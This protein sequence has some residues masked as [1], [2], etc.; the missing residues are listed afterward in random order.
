MTSNSSLSSCQCL[1]SLRAALSFHL[2][3]SPFWVCCL[4]G[5][6]SLAPPPPIIIIILVQGSAPSSSS[7]T[8]GI[9]E[10]STI[11]Q[12]IW[13]TVKPFY[14]PVAKFSASPPSSLLELNCTSP[15]A[16][17][18]HGKG[19][20]QALTRHRLATSC[21]M[22]QHLVSKCRGGSRPRKRS[23]PGGCLR[24]GPGAQTPSTSPTVASARMKCTPQA[25]A[26]LVAGSS[27]EPRL[28]IADSLKSPSS[29]FSLHNLQSHAA[30]YCFVS[31]FAKCL[32]AW[33]SYHIHCPA[34]VGSLDSPT[35][36]PTLPP[37]SFPP[38][39]PWESHL[40]DPLFI[41]ASASVT[42]FPSLPSLTFPLRCLYSLLLP[43]I[44]LAF[45]L[46]PPSDRSASTFL[47][48]RLFSPLVDFSCSFERTAYD[49]LCL[50][51][52]QN[53][54]LPLK[55]KLTFCENPII[56]LI[57]N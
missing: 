2:I 35:R 47:L 45:L 55:P 10:S 42:T 44:S 41:S 57:E 28:I 24:P 32:A 12:S 16:G 39:I 9:M 36:F 25:L 20:L 37:P 56:T 30:S 46:P 8:L 52:K 7:E 51:P 31:S 6:L 33:K 38:A 19:W 5:L 4:S 53:F 13:I 18:S 23:S 49:L 54:I 26:V 43:L 15:Y 22:G 48:H 34:R 17:A 11:P 40:F 1:P 29:I 50:P 14:V 27:V 21:E 3:N